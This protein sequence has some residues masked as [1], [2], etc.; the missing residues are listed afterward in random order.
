LQ[1][2]ILVAQSIRRPAVPQ[3]RPNR[4]RRSDL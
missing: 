3:V 2:L 1:P 4:Q